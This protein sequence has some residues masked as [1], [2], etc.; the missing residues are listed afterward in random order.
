MANKYNKK[1][2][3]VRFSEG[4]AVSV[5]IPRIDRS[6]SDLPRLPCVVVEVKYDTYRLRY[7]NLKLRF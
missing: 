2:K 7:I 5:R 6:N 4:E 1:N 3:V